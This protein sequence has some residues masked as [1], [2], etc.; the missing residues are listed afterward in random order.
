[1]PPVGRTLGFLALTVLVIFTPYAGAQWPGYAPVLDGSSVIVPGYALGPYSLDISIGAL[2]WDLGQT[3]VH[4]NGLGPQFRPNVEGRFWYDLPVEVLTLPGD[5]AILALGSP[6]V[7][8]QTR[9]NIGPGAE[10]SKVL[11]AYGKPSAVVVSPS[12][13]RVLIYDALGIA[14]EIEYRLAE[15]GYGNVDSVYVFRPGQA[16]A[17]WRIP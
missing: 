16:G 5:N 13:P 4:L 14:F 8:Y 17:I 7:D 12:H 3:K 15:G 1:M 2:Y 9:K 11:A 6:S 10:E